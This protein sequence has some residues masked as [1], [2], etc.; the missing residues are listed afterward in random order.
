[1]FNHCVKGK[2]LERRAVIAMSPSEI[3]QERLNTL[4]DNDLS[5]DTV[6]R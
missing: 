5:Y 3:H 2:K 6:K 1:M 4:H